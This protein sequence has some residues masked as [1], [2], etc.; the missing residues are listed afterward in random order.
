MYTVYVFAFLLGR[1]QSDLLI[2][3]L[4]VIKH[5]RLRVANGTSLIFQCRFKG[6]G[7]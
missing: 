6:I 5:S 3:R 4:N 2:R 7:S 1:K